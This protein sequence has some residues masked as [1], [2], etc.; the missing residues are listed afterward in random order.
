MTYRVKINTS[1]NQFAV[2]VYESD[3][4]NIKWQC[5]YP[6]FTLVTEIAG[7][8]SGQQLAIP[9]PDLF[10]TGVMKSANDID[11]LKKF[12]QQNGILSH[13][14]VLVKI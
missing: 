5:H 1:N 14:D 6:S 4:V 3:N 8:L 9:D 2:I 12:L 11:G 13:D 7:H 10:T